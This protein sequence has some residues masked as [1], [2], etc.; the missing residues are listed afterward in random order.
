MEKQHL[1]FL[2]ATFP[3]QGHINPAL[4]LA[5]RL[6]LN[7]GSQVTFSTTVSAHR[8]MF[9]SLSEIGS[10]ETKDELITYIPFSDGYDDDNIGVPQD[11]N[12]YMPDFNHIGSQTLSEIIGS[13]ASSGRPVSCIIYTLLLP[14][15][16]DVARDHNIPS[17][18]YWIQ[19]ATIFAIYYQ[20]FNGYGDVV[21][22]NHNN[23]SYV[24]EL[25]GLP[26]YKIKDLPNFL[27]EAFQEEDQFH[28]IY[29]S[30]SQLFQSLLKQRTDKSKPL[31]LINT[32]AALETKE[33]AIF[34][35]LEMLPI[36]P[37]LPLMIDQD[38]ES[39]KG[40]SLFRHDEK[41]YLEWLDSKPQKSV[42]YM[43]FGSLTNVKKDQLEEL[44]HALEDCEKPY[45][46][47]VRKDNRGEGVDFERVK[48]GMVV[49]WCNQVK[50][51]S[52][53][54][55]GCFVTHCGW[56]SVL[57]SIAC[58]VVMVGAP[59][60]SDQTMNARLI[61]EVWGVGV[62]AELGEDGVLEKKE[63]MRCLD[64]V[65]GDGEAAAH[66]RKMAVFWKEKAGEAISKDGLSDRN[67]TTFVNSI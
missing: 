65:M 33:L 40:G 41:G 62:R 47:V 44:L 37:S 13:L 14:W 43:S 2:V 17:A 28:S 36:G 8:R 52:H 12:V 50:V 39:G 67:L 46:W 49:E 11:F 18:L 59:R 35:E 32:F 60:L 45:I 23:L 10:L 29:L 51:L 1:H 56:N 21:K 38:S 24:V 58:G 9:P 20:F 53:S 4:H 3:F 26:P 16:A 61:E 25:P 7:T 34:T 55:V 30:F 42:V 31:V 27:T 64:L 6:A 5:K 22:S 19:P 54:S 15:A 66:M 63:L 57:E 48:N